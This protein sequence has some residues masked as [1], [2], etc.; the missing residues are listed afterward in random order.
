ML[1]PIAMGRFLPQAQLADIYICNI[2]LAWSF[3]KCTRPRLSD[4]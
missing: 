3:L 4:L 2:Q 1:T